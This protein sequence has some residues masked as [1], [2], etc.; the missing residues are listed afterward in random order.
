MPDEV[1]THVIRLRQPWNHF[2][3]GEQLVLSR[4]F[5]SPTGLTPGT[6]VWLVAEVE[7]QLL[8][9]TLNNT[10]LSPTPA[11]QSAQGGRVLWRWDITDLLKPDR[12]DLE[13]VVSE[14]NA[15]LP[16]GPGRHPPSQEELPGI[17]GR[18]YLEIWDDT[19]GATL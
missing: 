18:V 11:A 6:R 16:G 17:N 14:R 10:S 5:H 2:R 13:M 1:K 7:G 3:R 8:S 15:V 9:A 12:N 19:G 4:R